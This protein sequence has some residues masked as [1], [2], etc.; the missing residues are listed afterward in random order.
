MVGWL[1]ALLIALIAVS[2]ISVR[3]HSNSL[4]APKPDGGGRINAVSP[5]FQALLDTYGS[6]YYTYRKNGDI[7]NKAVSEKAQAQIQSNLDSMREQINQNQMYIQTFLDDY[8]N[9]NPE[10]EKLHAK[11]QR[12]Q[13]DGPLISNQLVTSAQDISRPVDIS[14]LT[15]RVIVLFLIIGASLLIHA[16]SSQE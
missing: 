11:S 10:L 3:E 12:L 16:F 1:T 6:S 2:T 15:L 14:G 13:Q 9:T 7:A 4:G 8:K 5:E